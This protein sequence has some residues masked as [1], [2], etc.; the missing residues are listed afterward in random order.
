MFDLSDLNRFLIPWLPNR[1]YAP[2]PTGEQRISDIKQ[3]TL[4]CPRCKAPRQA[5]E[6]CFERRSPHGNWW[7]VFF[8]AY[9]CDDCN[10][11]YNAESCSPDEVGILQVAP[12]TCPLCQH[13]NAPESRQ[14]RGCGA[15]GD[16]SN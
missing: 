14:C 7:Q 4:A 3:I 11:L 2:A 16:E 9:Q 10:T 12:W 5:T 15:G 6:K 1:K 8:I 13:T